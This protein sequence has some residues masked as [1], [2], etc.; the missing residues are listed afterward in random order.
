[1]IVLISY[2]TNQFLIGGFFSTTSFRL[3]AENGCKG[4]LTYGKDALHSLAHMK[5]AL[6]KYTLRMVLGLVGYIA[7]LFALNYFYKENLPHKY[8]LILLPTLPMLYMV[9]SILRHITA[10]DEMWRKIVMEAMAFSG[11]ATG[12]TCF[13]Y[14][15]LRDM[16]AP[17]FRGEWAFYMMWGYYGI[18]A[19]FS[20]WRYK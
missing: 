7:G 16:G 4:R 19:I 18:G 12:F 11:L 3:R 10:M 17:E 8:W 13:G 1:M 9:A 5:C 15:F 2:T 20:R 14:L 6:K